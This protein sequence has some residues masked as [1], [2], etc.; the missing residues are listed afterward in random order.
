DD[1]RAAGWAVTGPQKE[2]DRDAS[3]LQWVHATKGFS[4][5]EQFTAI[6]TEIGAPNGIFRDFR[7]VRTSGFA[8]VTFAVTGTIDAARVL[9]SFS[10]PEVAQLLGGKALGRPSADVLKD[11]ANASLVFSVDLP[12]DIEGEADRIDG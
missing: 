5:S 8:R 6:M 7:L 2:V 1:A 3:D 4:N 9:E 11:A 10:D 12:G